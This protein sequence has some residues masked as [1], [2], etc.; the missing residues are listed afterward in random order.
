MGEGVKVKI[1]EA[2]AMGKLVVSTPVGIRGLGIEREPFVRVAEDDHGF[3]GAILD[4]ARD[5]SRSVLATDARRYAEEHFD[6]E[7]VA[8]PL[9]A[10]IDAALS[11]WHSRRKTDGR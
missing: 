6:C 10:F 5:R 8:E 2:L 11:E 1:V 9:P 4:L 7:K 3:A